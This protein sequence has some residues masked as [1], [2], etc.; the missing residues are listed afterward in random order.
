MR[1]DITI[2]MSVPEIWG[3]WGAAVRAHPVEYLRHRVGH[4]NATMRMVVAADEPRGS[5]DQEGQPNTQNLGINDNRIAWLTHNVQNNLAVTPLYWP[6]FWCVLGLG[7]VWA[8]LSMADGA[9]RRLAFCLISSSLPLSA[10]FL[11]VSISCDLRYHI[12]SM[13]AVGLA[14]ALVI[15][16]RSTSRKRLVIVMAMAV[17]VAV[18]GSVARLVI[19]PAWPSEA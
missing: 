1:I 12:W 18:V 11:L 5:A 10:S 15:A 6:A 19:A 8:A 13:T 14:S 3:Y 4:W 2:R 16:D 7:M 17:F 9:A